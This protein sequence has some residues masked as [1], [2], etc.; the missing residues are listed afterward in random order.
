MQT[1]RLD[2]VRAAIRQ[3]GRSQALRTVAEA[4]RAIGFD[5]LALRADLLAGD[6]AGLRARDELQRRGILVEGMPP[7]LPY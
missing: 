2:L 6:D 5:L 1:L 4:A 3:Q 7:P